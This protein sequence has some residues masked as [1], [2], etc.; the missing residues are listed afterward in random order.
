[1]IVLLQSSRWG[2]NPYALRHQLLRPAR[3]P[4]PSPPD[5]WGGSAYRWGQPPD[6]GVNTKRPAHPI[7]FPQ[8]RPRGFEPLCSCEQ[9]SL[10]RPCLPFQPRP[11][12][13]FRSGSRTRSVTLKPC[14]IIQ[15]A[16]S[17]IH[18][19]PS[20]RHRIRTCTLLRVP[21]PQAGA[22]AVSPDGHFNQCSRLDSNQQSSPSEGG[23]LSN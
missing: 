17:H 15:P 16:A 1:M 18:R 13:G 6:I 11:R 20:A 23:A 5:M 22:S 7:S 12:F 8:V 14:G 10:S 9:T 3:L 4:I 21:A 2:S 19:N